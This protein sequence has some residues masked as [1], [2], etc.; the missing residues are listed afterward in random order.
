MPT[1]QESLLIVLC[2]ATRHPFSHGRILMRLHVYHA[3]P[4]VVAAYWCKVREYQPRQCFEYVPTHH[5]EICQGAAGQVL[6]SQ[7]GLL[8]QITCGTFGSIPIVFV[9]VVSPHTVKG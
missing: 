8:C 7:P 3:T 1:C 6:P 9:S 4:Q 2:I 5:C